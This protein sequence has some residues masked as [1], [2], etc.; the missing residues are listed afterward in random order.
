MSKKTSPLI[1]IVV[2]LAAIYLL[3][4]HLRHYMAGKPAST[5]TSLLRQGFPLAQAADKQQESVIAPMPQNIHHG[6]TSTATEIDAHATVEGTQLQQSA[7]LAESTPSPH[8]Q[9]TGSQAAS[10]QTTG[11]L[12]PAN[13][14]A[15]TI[16]NETTRKGLGYKF[17]VTYYPTE[18]SVTV[19][20]VAIGTDETKSIPISDNK[21]KVIYYAQFKNGRESSRSYHFTVAPQAH[22]LSLAFAWNNDPRISID[23]SRATFHTQEVIK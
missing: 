5:T 4:I 23:E 17:V 22:E 12:A 11:N 6:A 16:T 9:P 20:G 13:T 3:V 21:L 18:F 14:R 2:A 7:Q 19:N 15:I 8:M 1:V 10:T